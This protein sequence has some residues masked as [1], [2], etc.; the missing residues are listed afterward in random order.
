[1]D[2]ITRSGCFY[3]IYAGIFLIVKFSM[4]ILPK[5]GYQNFVTHVR[6]I[7]ET[8]I[9]MTLIFDLDHHCICIYCIVL[10]TYHCFHL[11]RNRYLLF[12]EKKV[13]CY[14]L[15]CEPLLRRAHGDSPCELLAERVG[16]HPAFFSFQSL[17]RTVKFEKM[18]MTTH[19]SIDFLVH[20]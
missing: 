2:E 19:V 6:W 4:P 17:W 20:L 9:R 8:S 18:A 14:C 12:H 15:P 1:M 10:Y 13:N 16:Y 7:Q 5:R 11:V 3:H